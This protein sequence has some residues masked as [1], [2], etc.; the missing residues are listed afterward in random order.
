MHV[1]ELIQI[2]FDINLSYLQDH[3]TDGLNYHLF[4]IIRLYYAPSVTKECISHVYGRTGF[5]TTH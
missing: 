4:N 2:A 5:H 3:I 1:H